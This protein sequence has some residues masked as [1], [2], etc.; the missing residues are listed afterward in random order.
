MLGTQ[1]GYVGNAGENE[2]DEK[3][4]KTNAIFC[5]VKRQNSFENILAWGVPSLIGRVTVSVT[6]QRVI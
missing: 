1:S 4:K 6:A 5:L 3:K 2:N